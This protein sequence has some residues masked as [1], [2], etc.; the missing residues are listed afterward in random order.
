[1]VF[2]KPDL[3][4]VDNP[5]DISDK[6]QTD[7]SSI[8]SPVA[9]ESKPQVEIFLDRDDDPDEVYSSAYRAKM[10]EESA[11]AR[12]RGRLFIRNH[13]KDKGNIAGG[14]SRSK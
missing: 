7:K 14:E 6:K 13:R 8:A 1:M 10:A 12:S 11:L 3:T 4:L 2:E 5:G 9:E